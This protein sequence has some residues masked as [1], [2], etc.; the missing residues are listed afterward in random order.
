MTLYSAS[1]KYIEVPLAELLKLSD[2]IG[3]LHLATDIIQKGYVFTLKGADISKPE[4]IKKFM[5]KGIETVN[6]EITSKVIELIIERHPER[7]AD[8]DLDHNVRIVTLDELESSMTI[9]EEVYDERG[10]VIIKKWEKLKAD[11]ISFIKR[12]GT[13]TEYEVY[14][15]VESDSTE[16]SGIEEKDFMPKVLI[17]DDQVYVTESLKMALE[18]N[19]LIVETLNKTRDF[20]SFIRKAPP[21]IM[22]LDINMPDMDGFQILEE[23]KKFANLSRIPV[24]MLTARNNREDILNAMRLG[25]ADYIVKPYNYKQALNKIN[26]L[27]PQNK[28]IDVFIKYDKEKIQNVSDQEINEK[29]NDILTSI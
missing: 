22:L 11:H 4:I 17:V 7:Y 26:K 8:K 10:R 16:N 3:K 15:N 19:G 25:A 29:L 6:I 12:L 21:D 14:D 23:M 13:K 28:K 20:I 9:R 5:D 2:S 24:I 1:L 18:D 27:L